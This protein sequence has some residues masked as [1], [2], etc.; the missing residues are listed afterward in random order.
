MF[1][2]VTTS[3]SFYTFEQTALLLVALLVCI[4]CDRPS[5]QENENY[6]KFHSLSPQFVSTGRNRAASVK[7]KHTEATALH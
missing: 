2:C 4:S 7:M 1:K 3:V 5:R 6:F